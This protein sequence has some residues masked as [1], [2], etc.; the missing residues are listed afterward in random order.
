MAKISKLRPLDDR[1]VVEPVE[2]EERTAGGIVLP[3]AAREKPQL[4]TVLAVGPGKLLENGQRG[5]LSVAV[6]DRVYFAKYGGMEQEVDGRDVKI[7]RE[8][9][10]LA[11][12]VD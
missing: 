3:D 1:V 5:E 7:L 12:V 6:G 4:G 11:K 10:I 8:S 2:A 9:D